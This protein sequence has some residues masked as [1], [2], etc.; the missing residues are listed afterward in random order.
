MTTGI[1]NFLTFA[2]QLL[3]GA[4][5]GES[6]KY[7]GIYASLITG[8]LNAVF[9]VVALPLVEKFGR[10]PLLIVGFLGTAICDFII[11]TNL[12]TG[13]IEVL[14]LIITIL[15]LFFY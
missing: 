12:K 11:S 4:I 2:S 1:L 13:N 5:G 15:F 10:K 9:V 8:F 3:S 6:V 14:T 7:S